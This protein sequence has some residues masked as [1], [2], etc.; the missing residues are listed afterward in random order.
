MIKTPVTVC[1]DECDES[2]DTYRKHEAPDTRV[3]VLPKDGDWIHCTKSGEA[4]PRFYCSEKCQDIVDARERLKHEQVI[5]D[6]YDGPGIGLGAKN[7]IMHDGTRRPLD[8][9]DE[10]VFHQGHGVVSIA[11]DYD[12][13][14]E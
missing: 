8:S 12:V 13:E 5:R 1:C 2:I 3:I 6:P 11:N 9:L 14:F 4:V 10:H 7:V